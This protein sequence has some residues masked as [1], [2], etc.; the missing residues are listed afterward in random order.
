MSIDLINRK[1][2]AEFMFE[3]R[4][5]TS[6]NNAYDQ[7]KS[8]PTVGTLQEIQQYRSIGTVEQCREAMEKQRAKKPI[9]DEYNHDCCPNCGWIVYKDE[10]GGRNLLCCENCGQI[11]DWDKGAVGMTENEARLILDVRIS[12][13]DHANDVNK[14]LDVA[15]IALEEVQQ[16]RAIG[17]VKKCQKAMEKQKVKNSKIKVQNADLKIGHV[18]FKAG[19]KTY[20]CPSCEKAITGSEN[21][22]RWCGQAINRSDAG[23]DD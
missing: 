23:G 3:N 13:F 11:I 16:Y 5:C 12:R 20:W 7:L 4:Y 1:L 8:I 22:C 19:T 14:A 9:K 15:K 2:V 18:I 10:Y 21:Y 17:T 6:I